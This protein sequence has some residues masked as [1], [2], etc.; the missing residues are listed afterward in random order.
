VNP[1]A[2]LAVILLAPLAVGSIY[3]IVTV[4]VSPFHLIGLLAL[5]GLVGAVKRLRD[6]RDEELEAE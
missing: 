1:V 5:V 2:L 3:Q 6:D 4:G